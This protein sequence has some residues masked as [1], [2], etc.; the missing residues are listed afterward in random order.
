MNDECGGL[1]ANGDSYYIRGDADGKII[2]TALYV[3]K[4]DPVRT[5]STACS[6]SA[7]GSSAMS[8]VFGQTGVR[9]LLESVENEN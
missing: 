1:G 5:Y 2:S 7:R 6:T 8:V 3:L 9:S 4:A